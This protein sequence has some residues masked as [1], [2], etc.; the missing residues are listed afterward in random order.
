M[1]SD[2]HMT[3]A[4]TGDDFGRS[5]IAFLSPCS[6]PNSRTGRPTDTKGLLQHLRGETP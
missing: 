5:E 3:V 2:L 6:R 4:P 1:V